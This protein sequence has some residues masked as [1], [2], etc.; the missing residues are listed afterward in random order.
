[1]KSKVF[2]YKSYKNM[3]HLACRFCNDESAV[4]VVDP[5]LDLRYRF[6]DMKGL[7]CMT[8]ARGLK[9]DVESV[10]ANYHRWWDVYTK[11]RDSTAESQAEKLSRDREL[12]QRMLNESEGLLDAL[13]LPNDLSA[14]TVCEVTA[15]L[16]NEVDYEQNNKHIFFLE[17]AGM[18]KVEPSISNAHL[19]GLP[20]SLQYFLQ[21]LFR[22]EL[23]GNILNVTVSPPYFVRGAIIDGVNLSKESFPLFATD[24]HKRSLYLTGHSIPSLVALFVKKSLTK[25]N[26]WPLRLLSSGA[27]YNIPGSVP[28][29]ILNLNNISQRLKTVLL[30]LCRT[31]EEENNEYKFLTKSV[32]AILEDKLS[33]EIASSFVPAHK[34]LNFESGATGLLTSTEVEATIARIS[35]IGSYISRRLCI[36]LDL[37]PKSVDFVRMVFVDIDLTRI[38]ASLIEK[39]VISGQSVP[40]SINPFLARS[41]MQFLNSQKS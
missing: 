37:K 41:L 14:N 22:E 15:P 36:L 30:S 35:T 19:I 10:A 16:I 26:R 23:T 11:W 20:A 39:Y 21:K 33:L 27:S 32:Q 2:V 40:E 8:E 38:V 5:L 1:M 34:L 13:R 18:I 9:V 25:T 3:T 24:A 28:S 4:H 29:S 17:K 31:D 7:K 6:E 12:R